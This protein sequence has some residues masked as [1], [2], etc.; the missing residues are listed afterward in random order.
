MYSHS[1]LARMAGNV[2]KR[3]GRATGS[4]RAHGERLEEAKANQEKQRLQD[5]DKQFL[6]TGNPTNSSGEI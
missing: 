4:S 3:T 1:C 2:A 5:E 6:P